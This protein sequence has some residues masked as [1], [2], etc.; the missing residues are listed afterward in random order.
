MF[1]EWF[2]WLAVNWK[3]AAVLIVAA[4]AVLVWWALS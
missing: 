4:A 3:A 1:P 2:M